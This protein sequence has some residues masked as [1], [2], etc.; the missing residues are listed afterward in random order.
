MNKKGFTLTELLVV[1]ALL[2]TITSSTIFG[3]DEISRQAEERSLKELKKEIEQ[4]TDIYYSN[5]DV[6]RKSLLNGEVTE[7]CTRL[8]IL[9]N[10]N[11]LD[12]NLK[13]PVTDE[14]I[15]GNLCVYSRLKDGV[16]VHTF[17]I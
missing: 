16:I 3:I 13:N 9:Q 8:Y 2:V 14:N 10:E 4:A 11:L 6:Y 15:P 12:I 7:R 17:E 1:I 5:N